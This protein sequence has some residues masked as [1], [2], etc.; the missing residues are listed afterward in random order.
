MKGIQICTNNGP[1]PLQREDNNKK[2]FFVGQQK[3]K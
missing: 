3:L 1:G 2:I